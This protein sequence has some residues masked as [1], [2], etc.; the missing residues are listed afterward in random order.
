VT[1]AGTEHDRHVWAATPRPKGSPQQ[2]LPELV[3]H[4]RRHLEQSLRKVVVRG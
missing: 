1:E 2:L 4:L 3:I